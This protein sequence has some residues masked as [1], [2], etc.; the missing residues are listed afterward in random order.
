MSRSSAYAREV[1]ERLC[2]TVAEVHVYPGESRCPL[3]G[4]E[5]RHRR[6]IQR[7]SRCHILTPMDPTRAATP[8]ISVTFKMFEPTRLPTAMPMSPRAAATPDTRNSGARPSVSRPGR[9]WLAVPCG[10]G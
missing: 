2:G 10:C 1:R 3:G 7:I 8:R 4:S 6:P 9:G 5:P